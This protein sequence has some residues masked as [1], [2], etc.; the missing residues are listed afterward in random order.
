ML[1]FIV[2][3]DRLATIRSQEIQSLLRLCQQ[4]CQYDFEQII[5]HL[6][7][8]HCLQQKERRDDTKDLDF[9]I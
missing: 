6:K 8:L 1:E 5:S 4:L 7:V 2:W 3:Q 9:D